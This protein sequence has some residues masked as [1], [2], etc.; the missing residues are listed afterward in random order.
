MGLKRVLRSQRILKTPNIFYINQPFAFQKF[1]NILRQKSWESGFSLID[2]I[3]KIYENQNFTKNEVITS[4]RIYHQR[5][6]VNKYK[7][8]SLKNIN[9]QN[10]DPKTIKSIESSINPLISENFKDKIDKIVLRRSQT[11]RNLLIKPHNSLPKNL[12]ASQNSEFEEKE[13]QESYNYQVNTSMNYMKRPQKTKIKLSFDKTSLKQKVWALMKENQESKSFYTTNG[14]NESFAG[15]SLRN[16]DKSSEFNRDSKEINRNSIENLTIEIANIDII[17]PK[18]NE[19]TMNM[20]GAANFQ[21]E[22]DNLNVKLSI[23]MLILL[24]L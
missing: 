3:K 22:F 4:D 23:I 1:L 19:N 8:L 2:L 10:Q 20:T 13:N 16:R 9:K 24:F 18:K 12:K 6:S 21:E 7:Y 15:V 14:N 17:S 11:E 5:N